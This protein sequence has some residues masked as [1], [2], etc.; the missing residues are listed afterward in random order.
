[1]EAGLALIG[2]EEASAA[3][4]A[5]QIAAYR[6]VQEA[7]SN[8]VRHASGSAVTVQVHADAS[9]IRVRVRNTAAPS[10]TGSERGVGHGLRGMRERA[11][12]LGGRLSAGPV[13]GDIWQVEATLPLDPE[14]PSVA[15]D[16]DAEPTTVPPKENP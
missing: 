6:I 7:L 16:R 8:A 13:A 5:V 12:L 1:V 15:D 4:A 9:T 2:A 11:E 3:P 10:D 14:H